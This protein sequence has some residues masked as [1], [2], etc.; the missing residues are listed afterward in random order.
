MSSQDYTQERIDEM[1]ERLKT[2]KDMTSSTKSLSIESDPF[3]KW[4]YQSTH[5]VRYMDGRISE[6]IGKEN[7]DASTR[8]HK[9]NSIMEG[10][11]FIL[12]DVSGIWK[13]TFRWVVPNVISYFSIRIS[14]NTFHNNLFSVDTDHDWITQ[15][16]ID[17]NI[18]ALKIP[19]P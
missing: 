15:F 3:T 11:G 16:V 17:L 10:W 12:E 19:C 2:I 14:I 1:N 18:I 4:D 13:H 5:T 9:I 8:L 6:D 7:R